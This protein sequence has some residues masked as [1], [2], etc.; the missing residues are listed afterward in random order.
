MGVR[1]P[2]PWDKPTPHIAPSRSLPHES[3]N[4]Q[5]NRHVF[6]SFK[7]EQPLRPWAMTRS[8]ADHFFNIKSNLTGTTGAE[9]FPW[10]TAVRA[11]A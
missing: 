11:C 1:S 4:I 2:R 10:P 7:L 6:V 9:S 8:G 3:R 5:V